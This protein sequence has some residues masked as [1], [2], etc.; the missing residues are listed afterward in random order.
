MLSKPLR[1][2]SLQGLWD[3]KPYLDEINDR[4]ETADYITDDPV[5][6]I[7][8]YD[9]KRDQE[10]AGFLA[11]TMAW[12]RRDIVIAKVEDLMRRMEHDPFHFVMN[13]K[14]SDFGKLRTFK[15]RT[16]KPIDMHGILLS[17]KNI[18]TRLNDFESFWIKCYKQAKAEKRPLM[19]LFHHNFFN[20]CDDLAPRTRKHISNPEKGSTC[21]RL[22]MFLRWM[23]RK[24]SPVDVGMWNFISPSE[25]L[26]PYDVHVARQA[27]KYGLV[28]RKSNDWKTVN[29]L[30]KTLKLLN[31]DD[32]ARYDYALFGIG[33]LD[34][35]LP[36]KFILNKV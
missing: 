4:V 32:P 7:H 2:R 18:Y 1:Q 23:I 28:S 15:H 8:A 16:F 22:Y 3:I 13:Y 29:Q 6:F 33:A 20:G 35:S 17:L 30:T 9:Q 14:Q 34:Y 12:G 36:K 10:I 21:K 27:K 24:E 5:Q 19:A 26:I 31:P 25:L 11:A